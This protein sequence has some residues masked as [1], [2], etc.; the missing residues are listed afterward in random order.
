MSSES[1]Y[2]LSEV[3]NSSL[4]HNKWRK[5][6]IVILI[7]ILI[8]LI[9]LGMTNIYHDNTVYN[10]INTYENILLNIQ[11]KTLFHLN[12]IPIIKED[13][14]AYVLDINENKVS[15]P[16]PNKYIKDI[17][18]QGY[19]TFNSRLYNGKYSG[20]LIVAT[21]GSTLRINLKNNL[22]PSFSS[23]T[24][25][26]AISEKDKV[27][28]VTNVWNTLR[29]PNITNLHVHGLHVSP[30]APGDDVYGKVTP[31][32]SN[33]HVYEYFI[34]ES[35]PEGLFFYHPHHHGSATVQQGGGMAGPILILKPSTSSSSSSGS[36][37][38]SSSSITELE[39]LGL[40][41]LLSSDSVVLVTTINFCCG[42]GNAL[43]VA[44]KA[45][46][47]MTIDPHVVFDKSSSSSNSSSSSDD[48]DSKKIL[49]QQW[50]VV[51]DQ[52]SP[53]AVIKA[54]ATSS[55]NNNS[56]S[57]STTG[58]HR[59]RF[60]NANINNVL[61]LQS[62]LKLELTVKAD[63]SNGN[64]RKKIINPFLSGSD[65]DDNIDRNNGNDD[66][67]AYDTS[68]YCDIF[69]TAADGVTLKSP[70]ATGM[71]ASDPVLIVPGSRRDVVFQ[72]NIMKLEKEKQKILNKILINEDEENRVKVD[73]TWIIS[74]ISSKPSKET[75]STAFHALGT[76]SVSEAVDPPILSIQLHMP[77][78]TTAT[79]TTTT[80]TTSDKGG[81]EVKPTRTPLYYHLH[82]ADW[83]S[84]STNQLDLELQ[85]QKSD[86]KEIKDDKEEEEEEEEEVKVNH[87]SFIFAEGSKVNRGGFNY[88]SYTVNSLSM[89]AVGSSKPLLKG[90]YM[91]NYDKFNHVRE[92]KLNSLEEWQVSNTYEN[93]AH[94]FH[95]HVNHFRIMNIQSTLIK[96][97][98]SNDN[99]TPDFAVGDYRDSITIPPLHNIT[100]RWRAKDYVG[101]SMAHCHITTHSDTGMG[102]PF[103][104]IP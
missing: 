88:T 73:V 7:I 50:L 66:N 93:A 63:T 78:A 48:A 26:I 98:S 90:E 39:S 46:S 74:M 8:I 69:V 62:K 32:S 102:F 29:E 92:V 49:S 11:K 28:D 103:R 6:L 95:L 100:I 54:D 83:S 51:N 53:V 30:M 20:G 9:P 87:F 27:F 43:D 96:S 19:L 37:S 24:S 94:P 34:P 99:S 97:S 59:L 3:E 40:L 5:T 68:K 72:C 91:R 16:I 45:H 101:L 70:R 60:V 85:L 104:I 56:S 76:A 38:S 41:P 1:S 18:K 33:E 57:S 31:G 4:N 15:L 79:T 61:L 84:V 55:S 12:N 77:T 14:N 52:I 42:G 86:S 80:T 75:S 65:N 71:N 2:L 36:S 67:Y 10:E 82:G 47:T 64:R 13:K 25:S 58:V 22:Q 21:A 17:K 23:S 81:D 35:H 44:N 89:P